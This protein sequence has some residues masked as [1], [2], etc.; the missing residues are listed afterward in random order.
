MT[1]EASRLRLKTWICVTVVVL[2]NAFGDFFMKRGIPA[3]AELSRPW[4]FVATL[5]QPWVALGVALLILWQMSRMAL[6]SWAD[7]SYVLPVTSIGYVVV[8]LIGKVM[9]HEQISA[10]RWAGILLIVAGV[11]L[12]SSATAPKTHGAAA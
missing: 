1:A 11:A 10:T 2:S 9:L 3:S 8:A 4:Q 7:L 5:F 6:L 12:V